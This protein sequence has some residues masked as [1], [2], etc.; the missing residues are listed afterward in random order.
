METKYEGLTKEEKVMF[1]IL[2]IILVIAIGILII[3][4]FSENERTLKV[5]TPITETEN[6]GTADDEKTSNSEINLIEDNTDKVNNKIAYVTNLTSS[7]KGKNTGSV[8]NVSK[9]EEIKDT[10]SIEKPV[11]V[12]WDFPKDIVTL[13]E[14]GTTIKIDKNV[15]LEDGSVAEAQVTVRKLIDD[16]YMIQDI[17]KG[18]IL[19]TEGTYKYYY[20]YANVTKELVLTVK[21]YLNPVEASLPSIIDTEGL[22]EE[23]LNN[24][25]DLVKT[26]N[27]SVTDN[28]ISMNLKNTNK[29]TEIPIYLTL[30]R[31]L[32]EVNIVS[33][34]FG[35]NVLKTA[36][37]RYSELASN[38]ILMLINLEIIS[39]TN[40]D[41][42]EIMINDVTYMV[43][44]NVKK[45]ADEEK[46]PE[47]NNNPDDKEDLDNQDK[48]QNKD[49]EDKNTSIE[50]EEDVNLPDKTNP[51]ENNDNLKDDQNILDSEENIITDIMQVMRENNLEELS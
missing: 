49:E 5:E 2:G 1:S 12:Q 8:S 29:I 41:E 40:L 26:S 39:T 47:D 25:E 16:T 11:I 3:N 37:S 51:D 20:T 45:T 10:T 9:K 7:K 13:A 19:L 14:A 28:S 21:G 43:K 48:E 18:S 30:D 38:Q 50:T 46:D 6:K 15:V 31:D 33:K 22:D 35:I 24:Y 23:Y 17:S 4:T 34:T 32:T 44:V 36:S 42:V 27:I